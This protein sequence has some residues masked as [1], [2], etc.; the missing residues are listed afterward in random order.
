MRN[1]Q[2]RKAATI[3]T[4]VQINR[5]N[6]SFEIKN[7]F[8]SFRKKK[9]RRRK[10][11]LYDSEMMELT[12]FLLGNNDLNVCHHVSLSIDNMLLIYEKYS[13]LGV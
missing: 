1:L 4:C 11:K 8:L 10:K 13:S 9:T 12:L 2:R 7:H 6:V 3:E 5:M